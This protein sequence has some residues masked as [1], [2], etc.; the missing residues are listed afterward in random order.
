MTAI[1]AFNIPITG[2]TPNTTYHFRVKAVGSSIVYGTDVTFK[3]LI[4]VV[5]P[6]V[7]TGTASSVALTSAILNGNLTDKGSASS[8]YISFEWGT[9]TAYG[10]ATTAKNATATGAF[11]TSITG[12]APNTTYHFRAK[13]VGSSTVYGT[14]VTF[15]TVAGNAIGTVV[16]TPVASGGL[17]EYNLSLRITSTTASGVTVGQLVWC[18]ASTT[19]FPNLLT[20]GAIL[21]GYLDR[22]LGWWVIKSVTP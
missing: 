12:L 21:T 22:P 1:G 4:P 6:K 20:P 2:L 14:D 7:T 9:T 11:N 18:A 13:A 10:M 8:V 15:K 19:N 17:N 3:T 16:G 5:A